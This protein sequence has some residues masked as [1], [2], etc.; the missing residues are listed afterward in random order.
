MFGDGPQFEPIK[1]VSK[2]DQLVALITMH[3]RG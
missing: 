1:R 3:H 2:G